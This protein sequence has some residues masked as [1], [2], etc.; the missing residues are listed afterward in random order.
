ME[1]EGN[2]IITDINIVKDSFGIS[3]G[4]IEGGIGFESF[5]LAAQNFDG[6]THSGSYSYTC[7]NLTP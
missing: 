7:M 5:R 3:I 1:T 2:G 6:D 4:I